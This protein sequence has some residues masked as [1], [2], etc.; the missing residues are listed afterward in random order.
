LDCN[1]WEIRARGSLLEILL[2]RFFPLRVLENG[3]FFPH[4]E[5]LATFCRESKN[6]I[7]CLRELTHKRENSIIFS[8]SW[9]GGAT[10][11]ISYGAPGKTML[12][13]PPVSETVA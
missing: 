2:D 7:Y 5:G 3:C 1:K 4:K 9:F 12:H 11:A 13:V 10:G 6:L 8:D